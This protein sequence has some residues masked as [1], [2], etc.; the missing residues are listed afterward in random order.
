MANHRLRALRLAR[1]LTQGAL[2]HLVCAEVEKATG[3]Q[4]AVEAQTISRI[5]RGVITW[6]NHETRRALRVVLLLAAR[7]F[8]DLLAEIHAAPAAG[9]GGDG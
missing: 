2:A 4:A 6:P 9:L 5:E 3:H 8:E 1:G 7:M